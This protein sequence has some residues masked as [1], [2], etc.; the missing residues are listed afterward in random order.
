M[1]KEEFKAGL[2]QLLK[3]SGY[4]IEGVRYLNIICDVD[5]VP[6]INISY[7]KL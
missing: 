7:F 3:E 4:S 6:E 1:N 2:L 5:S